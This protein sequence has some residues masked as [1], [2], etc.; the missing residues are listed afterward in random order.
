[1]CMSNIKIL[2]LS[3]LFIFFSF[4]S[5]FSQTV[6]QKIKTI[7]DITGQTKE[8]RNW[9]LN[10]HLNLLKFYSDMSVSPAYTKIDSLTSEVAVSKKLTKVI[11]ENFTTQ[12]ISDIYQFSISKSGRKY[13]QLY[14]TELSDLYKSDFKDLILDIKRLYN[15]G[16]D[17]KSTGPIFSIDRPDGFY[18]VTNSNLDRD[19]IGDLEKYILEEQPSINI[20]DIYA[21]QDSVVEYG[22]DRIVINIELTPEG[23]IKFEKLTAEN[24]GK[25]I[26]IVVDK[27]ILTA[28]V[29]NSAIPGG[30]LQIAGSFSAAEAKRIVK[31]LNNKL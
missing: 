15:S 23:A 18:K 27:I 29:I 26:A 17:V 1:M 22:Y 3:V 7:L 4:Y 30:K 5:S 28:P 14:A 16:N 8:I 9:I 19:N 13:L 2:L 25:S 12:E 11:K 21:A 24:I 10:E 31:K 6:D 20:G